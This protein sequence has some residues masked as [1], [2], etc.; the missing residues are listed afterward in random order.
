MLRRG[1]SQVGPGPPLPR[2]SRRC[3]SPPGVLPGLKL[4]SY[5]ITSSLK[6]QFVPPF[7]FSCIYSDFHS[8]QKNLQ[9]SLKKKSNANCVPNF[10]IS[11]LSPL[12]RERRTGEAASKV[13]GC[14][15]ERFL[16]RWD[17]THSF[18]SPALFH[19]H[20]GEAQQGLCAVRSC[21]RFQCM[22]KSFWR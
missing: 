7:N 5:N 12:L 22:W 16:Q 1:C 15:K 21:I 19:F 9:S 2:Q 8:M 6:D 14:V 17:L 3:S 11:L 20:P 13:W 4:T 18:Q 10:W